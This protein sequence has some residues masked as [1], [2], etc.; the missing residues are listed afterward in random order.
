MAKLT[1]EQQ[2]AIMALAEK[3]ALRDRSK[4]IPRGLGAVVNSS[5]Q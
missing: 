1:I 5:N 2:R 3:E 4:T